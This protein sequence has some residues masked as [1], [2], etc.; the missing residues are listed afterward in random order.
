MKRVPPQVLVWVGI[1]GLFLALCASS[2]AGTVT[3]TYDDAGRLIR[4][5]HVGGKSI[6]YSYDSSGNMTTLTTGPALPQ[7]TIEATDANAAE[8][9]SDTA[10]LT[11]SRAGE[12]GNPLTVKYSMGGTATNGV[13][14][15][16]MSGS[17]TIPAGSVNA[18]VMIKPRNDK[19][20]E[21]NET[22]VVTLLPSSSYTLG[23]PDSATVNLVDDEAPPPTV[24][25]APAAASVLEGSS[26]GIQLTLSRTG[27][28]SKA[29][30]VKLIIGGTAKVKKDFGRLSGIVK[31]PAGSSIATVSIVPIPDTAD[32]ADEAV[33]LTIA[34]KRAYLVGS[35][36][37]ATVTITDDD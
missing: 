25:I 33:E 10:Q 19:V 27:I 11:V 1:L 8:L 15:S 30:T 32:E 14:Y 16:K 17:L 23:S 9:A 4:A 3:Y 21:G 37:K 24:S 28:T 6:R 22:V 13:D 18:P 5:D 31:I 12:M 29:L 2:G 36:G 7:V 35:P 26:S 20:Y 34:P